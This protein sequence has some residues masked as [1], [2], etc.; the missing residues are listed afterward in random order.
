MKDQLEYIGFGE[1]DVYEVWNFGVQVG[2]GFG[3]NIDRKLGVGII[4]NGQSDFSK[5][6]TSS[7]KT[8]SDKQKHKK[9]KFY[10]LI[11]KI[12]TIKTPVD[13]MNINTIASKCLTE[14]NFI[15]LKSV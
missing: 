1:S 2:L 5:F 7:G 15:N 14:S 13:A 9:F 10:R 6:E 3:Y 11:F 4:F 8:F 12:Q